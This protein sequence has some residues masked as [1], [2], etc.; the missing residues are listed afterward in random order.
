MTG[1]I[2]ARPSASGSSPSP[3]GTIWGEENSM[4]I[5]ATAQIANPSRKVRRIP[6]A[7][8]N[9]PISTVNKVS[10]ADQM[11][12]VRPLVASLMPSSWASQSGSTEPELSL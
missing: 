5:R 10:S 12:M 3:K 6:T 1:V 8:V 2:K 7:S 4:A 11:P 9:E